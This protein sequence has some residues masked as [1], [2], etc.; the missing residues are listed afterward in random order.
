MHDESHDLMNMLTYTFGVITDSPEADRQRIA[1]AYAEA[2][3]LAASIEMENGSARPRIVACFARFNACKAAEDVT[4]AAWMLVAVQE[5]ITEHD[6]PGWA[7][8]KIVADKAAAL[9]RPPRAQMH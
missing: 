1:D 9:L 7:T 8:L 4:A 3:A 5:R 6:L 2:Q